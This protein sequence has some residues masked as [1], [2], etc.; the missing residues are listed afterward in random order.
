MGQYPA[1]TLNFMFLNWQQSQ[2]RDTA[3]SDSEDEDGEDAGNGETEEGPEAIGSQV[4]YHTMESYQTY[5]PSSL[6]CI[7]V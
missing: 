7:A 6:C 5:A 4:R 2:L 1:M 3:L